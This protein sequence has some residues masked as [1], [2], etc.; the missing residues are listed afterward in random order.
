MQDKENWWHPPRKLP[1][2]LRERLLQ[3]GSVAVTQS[4]WQFFATKHEATLEIADRYRHELIRQFLEAIFEQAQLPID[5]PAAAF[6]ATPAS[7]SLQHSLANLREQLTI[8]QFHFAISTLQWS[9]R[10]YLVRAKLSSAEALLLYEA[11]NQILDAVMHETTQEWAFQQDEIR[12]LKNELEGL[13]RIANHA[14]AETDLDGVL[15]TVVLEISGLLKADFTAVLLP[16][17]DEHILVPDVL[18][19]TQPVRTLEIRAMVAATEVEALLARMNFGIEEGGALARAYTTG[20]VVSS[21]TPIDDLHVTIRRKQT[22]EM[23]GFSHLLAAPLK[24]HSKVLGVACVANRRDKRRF[25][26]DDTH[27]LSTVCA[28]AAAAIRN[29]QLFARNKALSTDLVFTLSQALD[30]RDSYTHNHSA[31]VAALAKRLASE[32]GLPAGQVEDIYVAGLLHDIGKI[33]IADAVL[34]KPGA[35]NYAER[36]LMMQHPVKGAQILQPVRGLRHL[37]PFIRHHHERWDG[38]GY[39]DGLSGHDIP[40]GGRIL[41]MADAYDVM[42]NHRVYR[43]SRNAEDM[44]R[45]L[46]AMSGKQFEPAIVEVLLELAASGGITG[47]TTRTG[48]VIPE[49]GRYYATTLAPELVT[50]ADLVAVSALLEQVGRANGIFMRLVDLQG[51]CL[52][53]S[54]EL[55]L[56]IAKSEQAVD[57]YAGEQR[58]GQ[59]VAPDTMEPGII[60]EVARSIQ[61]IVGRHGA[62]EL[63]VRQFQELAELAK[64]LNSCLLPQEVLPRAMEAAKRMVGADV[65]AIWL[66]RDEKCLRFAAAAG[67]SRLSW[68]NSLDLGSEAGLEGYV[69]YRKIPVMVLDYLQEERFAIPTWVKQDGIVSALALPMTMGARLVGV[70]SVMTYASTNFSNED[71]VVLST[72]AG[73]TAAAY[74]NALLRQQSHFQETIDPVSA[75]ATHR[76]FHESL[77]AEI[78]KATS[79]GRGLSLIIFD[80]DHFAA[81]NEQHGF[82][83]GDELLRQIGSIIRGVLKEGMLAARFGGE[84]FAILL[85][86]VDA[87]ASQSQARALAESLR[88]E[89]AAANFP[90]R[91]ALAAKVTISAGI[92]TYPD[93]ISEPMVL[94]QAAQAALQEAKITGRNRLVVASAVPG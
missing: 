57:V 70:M 2:A 80:V 9:I 61:E 27:L 88:R 90:A 7:A 63:Q 38:N 69:A 56:P 22:L 31:N 3:E 25:G 19:A 76:F 20:E 73:A 58:F 84:E 28:Q 40:L 39:P 34:H 42:N 53:R 41:A 30:A 52:N 66:A 51:R 37:I 64:Q 4:W 91:H 62:L 75:L 79:I 65:A 74:E 43:R 12:R 45:E 16:P 13:Y 44:L 68:S 86:A 72:I 5:S 6:L 23:L 24:M 8:D 55:A 83:T 10:Q 21:H 92:A 35:L 36:A 15:N 93:P 47:L 29:K 59:L 81:Y 49:A 94:L 89:V 77:A 85:A 18:A 33:G 11:L 87:P 67:R 60:A 78:K 54:A 17:E 48:A 46:R 82:L 32:L 71:V 1:H 14:A 26:T 50:S